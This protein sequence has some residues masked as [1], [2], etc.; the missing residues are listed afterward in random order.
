MRALRHILSVSG[1]SVRFLRL[2]LAAV[3]VSGTLPCCSLEDSRDICCRYRAAMRYT[4][5]PYGA[6]AFTQYISSLRHLLYDADGRFVAELPP[7]E[8]MQ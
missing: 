2:A 5:R 7:G 3:L 6:E 1:L 8:D 4:Y